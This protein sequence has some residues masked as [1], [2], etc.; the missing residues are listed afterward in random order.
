MSAIPLGPGPVIISLT[1]FVQNNF[2]A[3]L[4][5]KSIDDFNSTFNE[6]FASNLNVTLNG[7]H[8]SR[9]EYQQQLRTLGLSPALTAP[10]FESISFEGTAEVSDLN[11][12]GV[13]VTFLSTI[14]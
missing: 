2:T 14:Q 10:T 7:K 6:F 3:L 12:P 4:S 1:A 5:A 13:Q 9:D 8:I 11:V